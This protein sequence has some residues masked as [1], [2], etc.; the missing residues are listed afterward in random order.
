M[1]SY[2]LD[3]IYYQDV[4]VMEGIDFKRGR[5]KQMKIEKTRRIKKQEQER[6]NKIAAWILVTI[7]FLLLMFL[8]SRLV[9]NGINSCVNHGNSYEY[10][11]EHI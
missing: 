4:K 7:I 8:N 11:I 9:K 6:K 5:T 10:C 3:D 1:E 2:S